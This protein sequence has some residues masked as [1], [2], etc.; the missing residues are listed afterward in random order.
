MTA[1]IRASLRH[2][3]VLG[4]RT[5]YYHSP[6]PG[7][8]LVLLHGSSPGACSELNWFRNFDTLA[9]AGHHVVAVDQPGF[10]ATQAS[11]DHSIE[12]R[13]RHA[14][15]FLVSMAF[16]APVFLVGNSMGG[17]LAVLLAHRVPREELPI[18]GLVLAAPYPHFE[19]GA[20]LSD[21]FLVHRAR[22]GALTPSFESVRKICLNT[23]YDARFVTDDVVSLRLRMIEGANWAP[24][25][26]RAAMQDTF[27]AESVRTRRVAARTLVV[28]GLNDRSLPL[29]LGIQAIEHFE[30]ATFTFLPRCGHWPQTEHHE[31]FNRMLAQ[32]VADGRPSGAG[33]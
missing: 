32:F 26:A 27:E 9:E 24:F 19:M 17:L 14:R 21:S 1:A 29:G 28:W 13:Y 7:P 23:F 12:M 25:Q 6:A 3:D 16:E 30:D 33:D 20:E 5:G 15:A 18:D 2:K 4:L 22:L 10:G 31:T 11:S 8:V